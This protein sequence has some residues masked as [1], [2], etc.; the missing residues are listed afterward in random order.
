MKNIFFALALLI[1]FCSFSTAQSLRLGVNIA[2][3]SA[4]ATEKTYEDYKN[5]STV[6]FQ[7]ALVL[8]INLTE[9]VAI[10][11]ELMWIQKGNKSQ[12]I[13]N[14]NNK[15]ITN[16]RYNYAE[17]PVSLKL[18]FGNTVDGTS[19]YVLA[20]PYAG[21]ALNGKIKNETTILGVTSVTENSIDYSDED[22]K[23]RRLDWGANFGL[24]VTFGKIYLDA[25]YQLGINNLLDDD[26]SN[27]NDNSAY[28]RNRGIGLTVGFKF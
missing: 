28:M 20:G 27:T 19:F 5:E 15:T 11:P 4:S 3:M 10:Q 18:S 21:L 6:G 16:R 14:D 25:R 9:N 17:I 7:A 1:S 22:N 8:P 23:E 12:Y 2:S 26:A 13:F 24:G